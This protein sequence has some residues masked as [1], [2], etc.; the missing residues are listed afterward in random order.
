MSRTLISPS[1]TPEGQQPEFDAPVRRLD[2]PSLQNDNEMKSQIK[3]LEDKI[4]KNFPNV[5]QKTEMKSDR[6]K[7]NQAKSFNIQHDYP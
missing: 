1:A 3:N 7:V 5:K 2:G 4:E 6:R